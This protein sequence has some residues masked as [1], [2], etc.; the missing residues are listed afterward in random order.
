MGFAVNRRF[1]QS[2]FLGY[3]KS[4]YAHWRHGQRRDSRWSRGQSV[5]HHQGNQWGKAPSH[6]RSW[7][8][9]GPLWIPNL[10][11]RIPWCEGADGQWRVKVT[12]GRATNMHGH[13]VGEYHGRQYLGRLCSSDDTAVVDGDF[14]MLDLNCNRCL[15]ALRD[16]GIQYRGDSSAH[17]H[18]VSPGDVS[19]LLGCG[20]DAGAGHRG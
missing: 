7:I 17:D 15:Q 8:P 10:L 14:A 18:G 11:R 16:A 3:P 5:C 9:P 13:D 12:I 1:A 4:C 6:M 20:P 2:L 19:A